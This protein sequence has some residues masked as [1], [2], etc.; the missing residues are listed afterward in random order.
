MRLGQGALAC[1]VFKTNDSFQNWT[2]VSKLL[3]RAASHETEIDVNQ[4]RGNHQ[5]AIQMNS[6]ICNVWV[7][8]WKARQC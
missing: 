2:A 8:K 5:S 4:N 1:E 3:D 6:E 7:E